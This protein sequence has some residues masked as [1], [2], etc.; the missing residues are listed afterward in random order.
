[1]GA[2]IM[3]Y[4]STLLAASL[5]VTTCSQQ[6]PGQ[7]GSGDSEKEAF[8]VPPDPFGW[9]IV[10]GFGRRVG[11]VF[12]KL[13]KPDRILLTLDVANLPAGTHGAH[14]HENAKCD[15]PGFESAGAHWNWTNKEHGHKNP[16]GHHAGDLGNLSIAN[17]GRGQTTFPV[18]E[19]EWDPKQKG[20]LSL[21][22][23]ELADDDRTDPSGN[24]GKRIACGLFYLRRD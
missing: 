21:I 18:A 12:T 1:M 6:F 23:H 11:T 20:P 14:I 3:K 8:H 7:Q 22:I 24:S 16:Q 2:V 10:D 9:P 4:A 19:Q 5:F 17:D 15:P 13:D